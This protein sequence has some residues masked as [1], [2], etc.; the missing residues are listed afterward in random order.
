[1]KVWLLTRGEY[2]DYSVVG[3]YSTKKK[4]QKTAAFM[5]RIEQGDVHEPKEWEMDDPHPHPEGF[6]PFYV[7]MDEEGNVINEPN[8]GFLSQPPAA[9]ITKVDCRTYDSSSWRVTCWR[10]TCWAKDA[11]HAIKI[12]GDLRRMEMAKVTT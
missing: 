1:M 12:A 2:S 7:W 5:E 10:V 3:I 8:T 4:A 9:E 6:L 11:A